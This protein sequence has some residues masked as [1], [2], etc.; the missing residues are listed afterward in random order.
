MHLAAWPQDHKSANQGLL[1]SSSKHASIWAIKKNWCCPVS[2]V[3]ELLKHHHN[4]KATIRVCPWPWCTL[5]ASGF[6]YHLGMVRGTII[7]GQPKHP[8]SFAKWVETTTKGVTLLPAVF[9]FS[10]TYRAAK[11]LSNMALSQDTTRKLLVDEGGIPWKPGRCFTIISAYPHVCIL[12][13]MIPTCIWLRMISTTALTL[14]FHVGLPENRCTNSRA[15]LASKSD[16]RCC[17]YSW[18]P[19]KKWANHHASF[20]ISH[21]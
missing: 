6:P 8:W 21:H 5:L 3:C 4:H 11:A 2:L 18:F 16:E 7:Y 13:R 20:I 10:K 15:K 19:P 14:D 9:H 1:S 12:L 17:Q